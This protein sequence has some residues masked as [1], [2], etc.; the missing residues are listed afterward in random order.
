MNREP[1]TQNEPASCEK[2]PSILH[3]LL[4]AP[5]AP[6]TSPDSSQQSWL[7]P[8]RCASLCSMFLV[9]PLGPRT[10]ELRH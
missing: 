8:L 2:P 4:T 7:R 9:Q 10:M 3:S 1:G 6:S 5:S